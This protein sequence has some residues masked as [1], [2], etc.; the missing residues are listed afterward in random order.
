VSRPISSECQLI[1]YDARGRLIDQGMIRGDHD[2]SPAETLELIRAHWDAGLR[3]STWA[4]RRMPSIPGQADHVRE[5]QNSRHALALVLAYLEGAADERTALSAVE[6][7]VRRYEVMVTT[8]RGSRRSGVAASAVI[9]R[10]SPGS[11]D[12]ISRGRWPAPMRFGPRK[13]GWRV[14]R[15]SGSSRRT[16]GRRW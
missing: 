10:W 16:I 12:R 6:G 3:Y 9:A 1:G 14:T 15:V 5:V 4:L 13:H 8:N 7:I 11:K 2:Q